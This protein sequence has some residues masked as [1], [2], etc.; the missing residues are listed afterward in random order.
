MYAQLTAE[1]RSIYTAHGATIESA[2]KTAIG[3]TFY[4]AHSSTILKSDR[5]TLSSA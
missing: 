1:Q 3:D 4:S 2:V 5:Y